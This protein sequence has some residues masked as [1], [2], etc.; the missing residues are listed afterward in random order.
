MSANRSPLVKR[1][2]GDICQQELGEGWRVPVGKNDE[3]KA[4][5]LNQIYENRKI[6]SNLSLSSG[7]YPYYWSSSV[8]DDFNARYQYFDD[9]LQG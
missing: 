8:N 7:D 6:I 4:D 5:E 2:E 1:E 9:G 3:G